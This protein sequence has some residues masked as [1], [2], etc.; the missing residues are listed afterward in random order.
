V[1]VDPLHFFKEVWLV[2]FEFN[3]QAGERPSPVCLVARE[4]RSGHLLRLWID[5]LVGM[6]HPPFPTGPDALFVAYYASAE[7]GCFQA[8][9]WAMPARVLDLYCEFKCRTSGLKTPCGNGL[10]GALAFFGFDSIDAAEKDSMRQLVLQ[11]GPYTADERRAILD[12]CQTDVDALAKLLPAMAPDIDLPR[13]LLRGRYMTAVARMEWRGVPIDAEALVSFRGNWQSVQE[14]LIEQIDK[15]YGIYEGRTFKRDLWAEW[16]A[17]NNIPWPRHPSGDLALDDDTFREMARTYPAVAPVRELRTTLAQ[18]RLNELA[19]GA[20]GRNR[21]MLSAFGSKTSRNQPSNSKFIFGPSAW[22]RSLIRPEP[23]MGLAYIDWSQQE[24]AIAAAM[25]GDRKMQDAYRSGDFYLTFAKMA[26]A[27]PPDA[28]KDTHAAER[29]QFKT[30]ALGV[31][32]GLS[33]EGL[34]RKLNVP[35]VRGRDLLRMHK[36]TF[37]QFWRWSDAVQD[38]AILAGR[39]STVFGWTVHAG[40]QPNPRSLRN[41]P[42]QGNGAEMMRLACCLATERGIGL[43][44]PVHDALLIEADDAGIDA[45]VEAT[46][47]VMREASEIVLDGFHLR[48]DAKIVRHPDRYSDKR[49]Q[50]MWETVCELCGRSPA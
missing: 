23:G 27:V 2:D 43:C 22:L 36:E 6:L 35:P 33:A 40:D 25:S 9:G 38:E 15:Q 48:T 7:L 39:L 28:T 19:V 44:C 24:L 31:L 5:D 41:F 13:A 29:E 47:Q 49:G 10:L 42:M 21:C 14:R 46:Q 37:R 4:L 1:T 17:K 34:A 32:Y 8:L 18:L 3:A 12:Y 26:G 45:A 20:D 16:L 30:V 11:G 50:V